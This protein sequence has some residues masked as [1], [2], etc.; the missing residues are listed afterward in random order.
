MFLP[1][2]SYVTPIFLP[3]WGTDLQLITD[4]ECG[5]IAK[6]EQRHNE[7]CYKVFGELVKNSK[8]IME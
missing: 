1:F 8:R 5:C 6:A 2:N 7:R 3:F 4:L